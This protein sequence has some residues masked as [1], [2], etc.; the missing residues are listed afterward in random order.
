MIFSDTKNHDPFLVS[1]RIIDRHYKE[2]IGVTIN[3]FLIVQPFRAHEL[4]KFIKI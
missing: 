2:I 4:I 1:V 3:H